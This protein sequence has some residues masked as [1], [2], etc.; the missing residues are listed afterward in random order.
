LQA[1]PVISILSLIVASLLGYC[2]VRLWLPVDGGRSRWTLVLHVALGIGLG[3]GFTGC[4]YW[5][6]IVS[7]ADTLPAVAGVELV[8]LAALGWLVV[9]QRASLA[10]DGETA[11]ALAFPNWILGLGLAITLALFVIAFAGMTE[12]NPQ[13]GWDAFAIWNLRARF[14]AHTAT[15]KFAVTPIPVGTHT[16]YPLLMSSLVAR[17]WLYA[18]SPTPVAPIALA[19]LFA[20][21]LVLLLVSTLAL[22][23]GVSTG[24]LAGAILLATPAFM[25]QA[26]SQYADIPLAF[27]FLAALALVVLGGDSVRWLSLGG[28]FAGLAAFTKNEGALLLIA[29]AVALLVSAWRSGWRSAS[30]QVTVFML[31]ALPAV[32]LVIW[33]KL[34]LAPPDPLA[35]QIT[36]SLA[37]KLFSGARWLKAA[38]GFLRLA[39]DAFLL[40]LALLAV[41]CVLLRLR[42]RRE[43]PPAPLLAVLIVLAG[44]FAIFLVTK[45]DLDWLINTALDRLYMQVW[46]ALVL[47]VF[48]WLRRPEDFA[49]VSSPAKAKKT[50]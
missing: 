20:V 9:R 43:R 16:E 46:P 5:L 32:L 25:T 27:F 6:L 30:R 22:S 50:R 8:T 47:A 24:L 14:L 35:G 41:T 1:A 44:Y 29:L 31:G 26:P 37:Q 39:W 12:A 13:G 36:A 19:F 45:D 28:V 17:G 34:A 7:G 11:T 40:P 33:F 2:G 21:G 48:L 18:G 23:R 4:L 38:G 3:T 10:P 15:W 49:I 42:P